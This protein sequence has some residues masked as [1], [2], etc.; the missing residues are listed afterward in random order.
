VLFISIAVLSPFHSVWFRDLVTLALTGALLQARLTLPAAS[1]TILYSGQVCHK[2][3]SCF[4]LTNFL[5][6]IVE[7]DVNNKVIRQVYR[8][9]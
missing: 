7:T 2:I 1:L 4:R 9:V 3:Y 5:T 8:S 6:T